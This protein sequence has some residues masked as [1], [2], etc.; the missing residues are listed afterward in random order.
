MLQTCRFVPVWM[1]A[2]LRVCAQASTLNLECFL[3]GCHQNRKVRDLNLQK[4]QGEHYF[5]VLSSA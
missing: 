2:E 4:Q 1:L 5:I 3:V